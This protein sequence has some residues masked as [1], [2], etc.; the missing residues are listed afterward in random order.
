[1]DRVSPLLD[2]AGE[3][4]VVTTDDHD[5]TVE[6]NRLPLAP[7]SL[8]L[9]LQQMARAGIEVVICAGLS[10]PLEDTLTAAGITVIPETCGPVH[11]VVAA[12]LDGR[13][14]GPFYRMPGACGRR[15]RFRHRRGRRGRP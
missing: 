4:L 2:V 9:R 13:L 12:F 5:Q 8:S 10:R 1:M 3:L 7:S 15:G 11:E 14:S 6:K